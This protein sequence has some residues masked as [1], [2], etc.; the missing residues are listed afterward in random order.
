MKTHGVL[1]VELG[2]QSMDDEVLLLSQRGHTAD[3]TVKGVQVLRQYGFRVGLQLMPGLP[4]DSE[5]KFHSTITEVIK[6]HPDI[7]R[8]YPVLVIRGTEL[9][10]WYEEG[11]YQPLRLEKAVQICIE[12]CIRLESQGISVI[13]IGLMSSPS[14][15][16]R[17]QIVAGPWHPAFGSLVRSGIHRKNIEPVLPDPGEFLQIRIHAPEREISLLKGYKNQG[18]EWIERK[19]GAKVVRVEP[20]D[21]I[22]PGGIRI[23]KI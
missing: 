4:G 20:D 2:A 22:A 11:R 3:D 12:S 10:R 19:T 5:E 8:L 17:G 7:V 16:E 13:R 15:L 18:L 23:E 21:S 6:L 14:L 1:T 9:A